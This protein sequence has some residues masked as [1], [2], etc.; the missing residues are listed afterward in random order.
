MKLSTSTSRVTGAGNGMGRQLV[1]GLIKKGAKVAALDI[2]A[3]ALSETK[4]LAGA[5]EDNFKAFVVDITDADKVA[6]LPKLIAEEFSPIDLLIN[7]AGII[8]PFVRI[9]QLDKEAAEKVMQI[10]FFGP[11][12]LIK[13]FLPSL[14]E[15]KS[16]HIVNT[17]SM[18]AYTPVPGQSLYGASKAALAALTAGLRS[19]LIDTNINVTTV[20]PGAI[21]TNIAVNS[22]INLSNLSTPNKKIKMTSPEKAAAL[23]LEAIEKN[24]AQLFIGSDA[25][26]MNFL[27][28]LNPLFAARLIQKQMKGLLK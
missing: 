10:N 21:A 12:H 6:T 5:N 14:L 1:I 24:K 13:A 18:G 4:R 7:N 26:T 20:Y 3:S 28:R 27:A 22:G 23:I 2:D 16:A 11:F 19:E 8:Q 9:N 25:K 15:K 17:S